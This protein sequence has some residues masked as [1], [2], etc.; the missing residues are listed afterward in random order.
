M[1]LDHAEYMVHSFDVRVTTIHMTSHFGKT[2]WQP[3]L[4][5]NQSQYLVISKYF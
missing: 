2:T 5:S 3:V 1:V 4:M